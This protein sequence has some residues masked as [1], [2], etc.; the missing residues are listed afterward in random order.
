LWIE[1]ILKEQMQRRPRVLMWVKG[2]AGVA[3]NEAADMRAEEGVGMCW[4]L[5]KSDITTPAGIRQARPLHPKA[6]AHMK[7]STK[8][9][10]GWAYM[11]TDK[12][13]QQQ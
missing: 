3:G 12:R 4:Q 5:N 13:P 6:P 10:K 9:I 1:E 2:H 11:V 7:W 8:A